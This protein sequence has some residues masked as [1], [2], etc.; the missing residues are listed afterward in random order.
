MSLLSFTRLAVAF[1]G[2]QTPF[3]HMSYGARRI[4][5]AVSVALTLSVCLVIFFVH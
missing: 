3:G 1:H 2:T 5:L 4:T